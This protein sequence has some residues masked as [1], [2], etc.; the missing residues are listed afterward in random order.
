MSKCQIDIQFDRPDRT[1]RGGE[2]VQGT[3]R[4]SVQENVNSK[5][6]KLIHRWKTHGRG[7][8]DTGPEESIPLAGPQL[9]TAGEQL[10]I[11]FAVTAA[12]HPVSYRGHLI[13]IDHYIRVE[14]DVPWARNPSA[15]EE[16]ILTPG[17][18][19]PQ[20]TGQRDSRISFKVEPAA[21]MGWIGYL[22]LG[23]LG[24]VLLAVIAAFAFFLLPVILAVAAFFWIRHQAL[25]ARLGK[26]DVSMPHLVVAPGEAW[27]V[28][29]RFT[30]RKSFLV[31]SI[32]LKLEAQESAASGS[33]TQKTTHTHK[34]LSESHVIREGGPLAAGEVVDEKLTIRFPD[35]E[36]FSFD[37][38]DNKIKWN[39]EIRIDIP[40]FP[41]W[42]KSEDLQ[43]VP[44]EFF[45][46]LGTFLGPSHGSALPQ[47][48]LPISPAVAMA[49]AMGQ[50]DVNDVIDTREEYDDSSAFDDDTR[51]VHSGPPLTIPSNIE[52]LVAQLDAVGRNSNKQ[53]DIIANAVDTI[54]EVS[55]VIDR[56]VSSIGSLDVD[57]QH[58]NGKSVVGT[59]QGTR[60]AIQVLT[61]ED[62]NTELEGFRRGDVWQ[63]E[64]ALIGW[65]T[66]YNRINAEQVD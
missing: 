5:G 36:A 4:I 43:V 3:V 7:N 10:E 12:T 27:P 59:I 1:Y 47:P 38:S 20:M 21:S 35:T 26:V 30:A 33:G 25:S 51:D 8:A 60:Q 55:I 61:T 64:I 39:A 52:E 62:H 22:I 34:L 42:S 2:T 9:L 32:T 28:S 40:R 18:P 6:I 23:T 14:V 46:R 45:N 66:L 44:A 11:P 24:V 53:P 15:D 58:A 17:A 50:R 48:Q 54:F 13:Y 65:D 31:N 16:Y 57:E 37:A 63:T 41:D 19:P 49:G 56:I 29:I